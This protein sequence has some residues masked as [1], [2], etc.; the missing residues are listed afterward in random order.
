[1]SFGTKRTQTGYKP[2]VLATPT[3]IQPVAANPTPQQ[4]ER[5]IISGARARYFTNAD[6]FVSSTAL[7]RRKQS[8]T[9]SKA[10]SIA[11]SALV[12]AAFVYGIF[13]WATQGT[14]EL[15]PIF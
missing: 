7:P 10:L 4:I 11:L 6:A 9:T 13:Y 8:S 14:L 5:D 3:H 12:T 2:M 15:P 1:M